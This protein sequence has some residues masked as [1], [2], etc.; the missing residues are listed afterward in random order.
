[1]IADM[2][3]SC[4]RARIPLQKVRPPFRCTFQVHFNSVPQDGYHA[5]PHAS[6][7]STGAL[8]LLHPQLRPAAEQLA[9]AIANV[10][11]HAQ[12]RRPEATAVAVPAAAPMLEATKYTIEVRE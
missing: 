8:S 2:W 3:I 4:R 5:V 6:V 7:F 1:M 11:A 12:L 10:S 9:A